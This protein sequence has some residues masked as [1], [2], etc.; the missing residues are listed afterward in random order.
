MQTLAGIGAV[1][2]QTILAFLPELGQIPSATAVALPGLAPYDRDTGKERGKRHILGGRSQSA[3]ASTWLRSAAIRSHAHFRDFAQ[4]LTR[5]GKPFKVCGNGS[6]NF[7]PAVLAC[8]QN[9]QA[10]YFS[11]CLQ[12]F[13]L[14][15]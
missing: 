6:A 7:R 14:Y 15:C 8:E 10:A 4:R 2:S 9:R 5:K 3:P 12:K 1:A 11:S 13:A